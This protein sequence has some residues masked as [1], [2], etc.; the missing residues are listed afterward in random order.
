MSCAAPTT[1]RQ[2]VTSQPKT[3]FFLN[4]IAA[5]A[6]LRLHQKCGRAGDDVLRGGP[7]DDRL[8]GGPG[9]D[10]LIGDDRLSVHSNEDRLTGGPGR[11]R[12]ALVGDHPEEFDYGRDVVLDFARGEDRLD[13]SAIDADPGRP[14]DQAFAFIGRAAFSETAGQ[15][16]LETED[17]NTLVQV[18]I[19]GAGYGQIEIELPGRVDLTAAD[20]L[21]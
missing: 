20:F 4:G 10:L 13:L 1:N 11:D 7:G 21:L 12:F 9:D 6:L 19:V 18:D 17:G 8:D 15:V 2:Q 5:L 3:P 14:G 16:R